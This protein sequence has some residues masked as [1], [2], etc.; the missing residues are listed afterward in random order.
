M[1]TE[2]TNKEDLIECLYKLDLARLL[3][4]DTFDEILEKINELD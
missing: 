3:H 4:N 1:V 2:Y